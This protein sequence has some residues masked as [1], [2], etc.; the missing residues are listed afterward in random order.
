MAMPKR[1]FRMPDPDVQ[2][3]MLAG[4]EQIRS[5]LFDGE[6][7]YVPYKKLKVL[8]ERA[9]EVT[10]GLTAFDV[11]LLGTF[12]AASARTEIEASV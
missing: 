8:S 1:V 10:Q 11:L 12:L 2:A 3:A 6:W 4:L 5:T 9:A 7:T